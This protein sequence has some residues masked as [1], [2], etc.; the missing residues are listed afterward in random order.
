MRTFAIPALLLSL[1]SVSITA[2]A[3]GQLKPG[4]WEMTVK[5]DAVKSMPNIP[6][7]QLEQ[8]RKMGIDV[9]QMKD[10]AMLTKVCI[11]KK[12]AERDEPPVTAQNQA[13]CQPK[14]YQ[15]SGNG[16]SVD[17]VC[18]GPMMKGEGKARGTFAGGEKFTSTYD[19]NGSMHGQPVSQ[20][21]ESSGKW[22][23]ADCGSVKPLDELLPKK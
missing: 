20:H 21:Q 14:N 19:F 11:S 17:V 12:M 15:R 10:G 7:A 18:D 8:M 4:L 13:G 9:P 22:L 5:S 16:Y 6:P 2:T 3:A 1:L 23:G